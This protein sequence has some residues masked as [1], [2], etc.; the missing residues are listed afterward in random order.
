M[1]KIIS[2]MFIFILGMNRIICGSGVSDRIKGQPAGRFQLKGLRFFKRR[3]N[4][5]GRR[6]DGYCDNGGPAARSIKK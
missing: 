1:K 3:N 5:R 2:V 6:P 4:R